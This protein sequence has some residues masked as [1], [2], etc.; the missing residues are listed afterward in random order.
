MEEIR[1]ISPD[2]LTLENVIAWIEEA[3]DDIIFD[4]EDTKAD[5][6]NYTYTLEV[7]EDDEQES[8][9]FIAMSV[10]YEIDCS[11]YINIEYRTYKQGDDL[12]FLKEI[13][14]EY[15]EKKIE[16]VWPEMLLDAKLDEIQK[17]AMKRW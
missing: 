12:P 11:A 4:I 14:T 10:R 16:R 5:E 8:Y 1:C 17:D 9:R 2:N 7:E 13:D 3:V 15:F 6:F